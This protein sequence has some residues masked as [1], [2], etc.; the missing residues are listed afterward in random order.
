MEETTEEFDS[1]T[2]PPKELVYQDVLNLVS[3]IKEKAIKSTITIALPRCGRLWPLAAEGGA[4]PLDP[5]VLLRH[6]VRHHGLHEHGAEGAL[7]QG[8]GHLHLL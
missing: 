6:P 5:D 3:V 4:A 1:A 8:L 2:Q 7:L